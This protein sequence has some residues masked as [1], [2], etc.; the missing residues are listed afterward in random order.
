MGCK[1]NGYVLVLGQDLQLIPPSPQPL[2]YT[3]SV[4]LRAKFVTQISPAEI[5]DLVAQRTPEDDYL[6]FKSG[7][8]HAAKTTKVD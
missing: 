3:F 7:I 4:E 8:F 2:Q 5:L 1:T 6:E